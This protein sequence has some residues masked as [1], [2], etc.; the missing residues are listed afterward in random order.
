MNILIRS[1]SIKFLIA[2]TEKEGGGRI[3]CREREGCRTLCREKQGWN[4]LIGQRSRDG[5]TA[6]YRKIQIGTIC[7]FF[8]DVAD[9]T[10]QFTNIGYNPIR[11]RIQR[12]AVTVNTE[13]MTVFY[14]STN[15]TF[16]S[17]SPPPLKIF[18]TGVSFVFDGSCNISKEWRI[19]VGRGAGG[20]RGAGG[21]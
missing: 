11:R 1:R 4:E 8:S 16:C 3:L 18:T 2:Y 21:W 19:G 6:P 14:T 9:Q 5:S 10:L 15:H 7:I 17:T 12:N 20:R 13:L